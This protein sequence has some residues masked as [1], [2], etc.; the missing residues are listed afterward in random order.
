LLTGLALVSYVER[1][2]I[3]VAAKFIKPELGLSDIHM[4]RVFSS[5][6]VGYALFQ[7]PAGR[8][9]DRFGPRLVLALAALSWGL[10]TVLTGLLPGVLVSGTVAIVWTFMVLRFVLGVGEAATFPVGAR[11]IA[12]WMHPT[13]RGRA[14]SYVIAGISMGSAL[15]PPLIAWIMV[16]RGWRE[17]FYLAS[18]LAFVMAA[19]WWVF[20][21]DYPAGT[22]R[23]DDRRDTPV[24]TAD[25]VSWWRLFQNRNVVLLSLSYFVGGYILY[26][27][28]FWL[29]TYL[30]DVR[31]FSVLRSGVFSSLPWI[32]AGVLTPIG[33][34]MSDSLARRWGERTG[35]RLVAMAG[36][37][38]SGTS[39]LYGA[40]AANPYLAIAGLCLA[41]GFQEF[42]EGGFWAAMTNVAGPHAGAATG[43]LNTMGNLGGVASTALVPILVEKF[44]WVVALGSGSV[45]A[46]LGSLLWLGI[47]SGND[48]IEESLR[49]RRAASTV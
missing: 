33:G 47:D 42:T 30:V 16:H 48:R 38:L 12:N 10:M 13:E 8:M 36:L 28:V 39:L 37:T 22:I 15:T 43:I 6:L 7:V 25:S 45:L 1:S 4:G 26:I 23:P 19:V 17:S 44:G 40:M 2:N 35:R 31:Q 9:G 41:V 21:R 14:N 29:F 49:W 5:F 20:G 34:I 27:F 32:T 18:V 3:A 11:A 24:V 46:V